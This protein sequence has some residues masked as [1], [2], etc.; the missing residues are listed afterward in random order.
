MLEQSENPALKGLLEALKNARTPEEAHAAAKKL[1]DYLKRQ[2][3]TVKELMRPY[4][5]KLFTDSEAA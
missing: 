4:L 5:K 3:Q 1:R 2:Q